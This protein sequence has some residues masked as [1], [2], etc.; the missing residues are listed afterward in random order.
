MDAWSAFGLAIVYCSKHTISEVL[1]LS[2]ENISRHNESTGVINNDT[3]G[4]HETITKFWLM[5]AYQFIRNKSFASL[6][7]ACNSF[8]NSDVAGRKY[9]FN[10]YSQNKLFSINAR[11]N[12]VAPDLQLL[13][14]I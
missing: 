12:W 7:E 4:Y 2:R 14:S 9:P 13:D 3:D 8:I 5:I 1:D 10:Y 11:Y 6:S